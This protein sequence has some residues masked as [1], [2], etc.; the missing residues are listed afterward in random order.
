VTI[1]GDV[2]A[3]LK[4]AGRFQPSSMAVRA[5]RGF[6]ERRGRLAEVPTGDVDDRSRLC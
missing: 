6:Y 4:A 3:D 1:T 5:H 2:G